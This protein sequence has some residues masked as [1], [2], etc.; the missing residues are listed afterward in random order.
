[1]FGTTQICENPRYSST[2]GGCAAKRCVT[3][4][5]LMI[6]VITTA[7]ISPSR[8]GPKT[9]LAAPCNAFAQEATAVFEIY[10]RVENQAGD[11]VPDAN[12]RVY[13]P[14]SAFD[15]GSPDALC[16][17]K[18]D[19]DGAFSF[20][21][22]VGWAFTLVASATGMSRTA[23]TVLQ[24]P[25]SDVT[26]TLSTP[27][28]ITLELSQCKWPFVVLSDGQNV[29]YRSKITADCRAHFESLSPGNALVWLDSGDKRIGN[30]HRFQID[31]GA[32]D[33]VYLDL[34]N[35]SVTGMVTYMGRPVQGASVVLRLLATLPLEVEENTGKDGRF[36]FFEIEPGEW[37]ITVDVMDRRF[38]DSFS[39]R[40]GDHIKP[41]IEVTAGPS[42]QSSGPNAQ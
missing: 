37:R 20:N 15:T 35:N 8:N 21:L 4:S 9:S 18:A 13:N 28:S 12:I 34:W 42:E 25:G 22:P 23:H 6:M 31:P 10:G 7:C 29:Y 39:V 33:D 27:G 1:M 11:G 17:A 26:L 5:L 36:E 30:A 32:N 40:A 16:S 14:E 19:E 24:P 38:V 41:D 3:V 2:T